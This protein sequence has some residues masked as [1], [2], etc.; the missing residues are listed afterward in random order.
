MVFNCQASLFENAAE[1][2]LLPEALWRSGAEDDI[3]R[4]LAFLLEFNRDLE[5][6][7][8]LSRLNE[9]YLERKMEEIDEHIPI[10]ETLYE[11]TRAR[12]HE[13]LL[14]CAANYANNCEYGAVGDLMFNPRLTLVH[15]RGRHEPVV[16]KRHAPLSRQ[17]ADRAETGQ[18]VIIWLKEK[19]TLETI[20]KPLIP[21]SY[22]ILK[23]CG[24]ISRDYLNS[25]RERE[26]QTADLS[27]FLCS[28]GF[29]DRLEL[30]DW[31]RRAESEDREMVKSRLLPL[32][33]EIFRKLSRWIKIEGFVKSSKMPF[34]VI[35][36]PV[37]RS[38]SATEDGKAGI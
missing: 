18:K 26:V 3:K 24:L 11:C 37:L 27:A 14:L 22:E 31:L 23:T 15:I 1:E 20:K 7:A 12:L 35:P 13:L 36:T 17:F 21:H 5:R 30:E 38:S 8:H 6:N 19:T 2:P 34:S 29:Q 10:C 33:W 32:D 4:D 9:T 28:M 25:A 16:K